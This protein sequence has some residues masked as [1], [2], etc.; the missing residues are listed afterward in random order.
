MIDDGSQLPVPSAE[1]VLAKTPLPHLLV[2]AS[3]RQLTGTMVLA[4]P[5]GQEAATILFI[6]GQPT[7]VRTPQNAVYLGRVLLELGFISES[8]LNFSLRKL[9]DGKQLHGQILLRAGS[10]QQDKLIEGLRV[11][12]VRKLTGLSGLPP[13]TCFRYYDGF[14]ALHR[15]GGDDL[16]QVDPFPIV[17]AAIRQD[18]PWDHVH[19][20]LTR[21]TS[22]GMRAS[23]AA[24]I[25]RFAFGPEEQAVVDLLRAR[26][27]RLHEMTAVAKLPPRITQ[28]L[29]YCLLIT[30]QVELVRE[31]QLP[32]PIAGVDEE[33]PSARHKLPTEP[34]QSPNAAAVAKVQLSQ[35]STGARSRGA[36]AE[37]K[38]PPLPWDDRVTPPPANAPVAYTHGT[39]P[40]PAV[41]SPMVVP[42][43]GAFVPAHPPT[44]A[45]PP[46]ASSPVSKR[47]PL[48]AND[49]VHTKPTKPS[50]GVV[51]V[52]TPAATSAVPSSS[53]RMRAAKEATPELAARREEIL[54]RAEA[55]DRQNYFEMLGLDIDATP[56]QASAAYLQLAKAWHPDRLPGAL[57]DVKDACARVFSHLSE[58]NQTLTDPEKR[59]R[60]MQL[61]K[62]GGATPESQAK[63]AAVIG[64]ATDFQKAEIFL[65][66]SD[67]AQAEA[68]CRKAV[69]ADPEQAEYHAMLAWLEAQKPNMQSG[70]A[71]EGLI[72]RLTKAL[73]KNPRCERA[74]FYRGMLHKKLNHEVEAVRD[75][76]RASAL[77]PRNIDAQREV[78]IFEMRKGPA[79]T[80]PGKRKEDDKGGLFGKLFKK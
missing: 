51:K 15:Y 41:R 60:Y 45:G 7:K 72:D 71:S 76:K 56:D 46:S 59:G 54:S 34:P 4:S 25:A 62:E 1:G 6:E 64:A 79:S 21:V 19:A 63:I 48:S 11:Q 43:P 27:L 65:R 38:G 80:P 68:H 33:R 78:R 36:I 74:Y 70:S 16:I 22:V 3:D 50:M 5:S 31:S 2:Y 44:S 23:N 58:A 53:S 40:P 17:W 47:A 52:A 55:I 67:L 37:P 13:E 8:A 18:P 73:E 77:N 10:L 9:A 29:A 42:T 61:L 26:A 69:E 28:L 30:K 75:F 49:P 24:Q 66:R 20:A 57:A 14:D 12:L 39:P 35:H 32:P